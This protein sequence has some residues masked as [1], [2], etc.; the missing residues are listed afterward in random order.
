MP[1]ILAISNQ[2]GGVAKTTSCISIAAAM[3]E[4]GRNVLMVDFDPQG[5]L[6][7]ACGYDPDEL[8]WTIV[9]LLFGEDDEDE[10]LPPAEEIVLE[11]VMEGLD[12]MP[13]DMRLAALER[14]MYDQNGYESKLK[15]LLMSFEDYEVILIDCPPSMGALTLMGLSAADL[16]LV[17]VQ[18]EYFGSKGLIQLFVIVEVVQNQTNPGLVFRIF[19]SMY[20]QRNLV[21]RQ[22]LASLQGHFEE[23]MFETIIRVDTRLRESA[24]AGEPVQIYAPKTRS[25]NEYRALAQEITKIL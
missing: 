7:T 4:D 22:V 17:P 18:C 9:D 24:M 2:K 13:A 6:T 16:A 8:D 3:A 5:N 19:A 11:S 23:N 12:L 10:P 15:D 21:S 14:K 20:D 25:A 1:K